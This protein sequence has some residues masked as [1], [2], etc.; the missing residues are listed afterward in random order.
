LTNATAAERQ[1]T[2]TGEIDS[3]TNM[4]QTASEEFYREAQDSE[5]HSLLMERQAQ[6]LSEL[7]Q[8]F[9]VK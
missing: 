1:T 8:Q 2:V 3:N 6:I 7:L 9:Q 4:I 5:Q